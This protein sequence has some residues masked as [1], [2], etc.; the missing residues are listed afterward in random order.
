MGIDKPNVRMTIHINIPQS[1]ES[2][3]QEA[4]RAGRDGKVS[5]SVILFNNDQLRIASKPKE[6]IIWIRDVLMYFHKN[7]F[8]GQVKERVM[9]HELRSRITYQK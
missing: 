1:I 6:P 5:A 8:K 9:I 7:S 3:V 4:G 2:F